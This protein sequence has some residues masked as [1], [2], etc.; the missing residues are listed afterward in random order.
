LVPGYS[1]TSKKYPD[2]NFADISL[3]EEKSTLVS[4]A[5]YRGRKEDSV[6]IS[7]L[8]RYL[9]TPHEKVEVSLCTGHFQQKRHAL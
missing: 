2:D 1:F 7:D 3:S 6:R 4:Y 8:Q 9:T 5:L